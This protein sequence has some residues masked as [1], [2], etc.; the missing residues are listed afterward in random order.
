MQ[1]T[2]QRTQF[3]SGWLKSGI[4]ALALAG[5]LAIG[6]VAVNVARHGDSDVTSASATRSTEAANAAHQRFVEINALLQM[7]ARPATNY[8]FLDMNVLPEST[9]RTVVPNYRFRDMNILPGDDILL[10]H[11]SSG[12]RGQALPAQCLSGVMNT[13]SRWTRRGRVR[14]TNVFAYARHA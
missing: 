6:G 5:A 10:P 1:A 7:A 13:I 9:L 4:A 2:A 12:E 11:T 3:P 14:A 8:R